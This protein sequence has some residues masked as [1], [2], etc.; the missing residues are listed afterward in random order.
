MIDYITNCLT[1]LILKCISN[2]HA[3]T[4]TIIKKNLFLYLYYFLLFH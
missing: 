1:H 4:T 2:F 3:T